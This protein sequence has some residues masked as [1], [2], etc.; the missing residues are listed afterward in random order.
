M[1]VAQSQIQ[2]VYDVLKLWVPDN[3]KRAALLVDLTRVKAFAANKS[4]RQ[5]IEA[6][7]RVRNDEAF[8]SGKWIDN[9]GTK[10]GK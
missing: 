5:T 6:L 7:L 1:S 2:E 4:Y 9:M 8:G 3:G 10:K